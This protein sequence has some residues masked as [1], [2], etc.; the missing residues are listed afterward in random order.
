MWLEVIIYGIKLNSCGKHK[1]S[2]SKQIG[3]KAQYLGVVT[4]KRNLTIWML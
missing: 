2:E 3:M 4:K 1:G